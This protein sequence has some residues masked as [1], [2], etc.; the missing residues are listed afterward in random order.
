[1]SVWSLSKEQMD[2]E[3]FWL[4]APVDPVAQAKANRVP[5]Y[6][7]AMGRVLM[8]QSHMPI[9]EHTGKIMAEVPASYLA[10]VNAQPWAATWPHW[11]PVAD[12]LS[13]HP[14]A[15]ENALHPPQLIFVSDPIA[16]VP[17]ETW[18]WT[19]CIRLTA[20]RDHEAELHAFAIGALNL[21]RDWA[22]PASR[23][24]PVHYRLTL[25]QGSRARYHGAWHIAQS[26]KE[27]AEHFHRLREDGSATCTKHCYATE[28]EANDVARDRLRARR[29]RPAHLRAYEC[30]KCGFWHLTKQASNF[31]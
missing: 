5:H 23:D 7:R 22:R 2:R 8:P 26:P 21:R 1:M 13:R 18:R 16:T 4:T 12:Y 19:S 20:L 3:Q 9:G 6:N 24:G 28:T 30:P 31:R 27:R 10:W 14:F 25:R 29:G 11:Q 15:L 17:D